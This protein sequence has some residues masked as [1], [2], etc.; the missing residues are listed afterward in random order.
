MRN[1]LENFLAVKF[2]RMTK[3]FLTILANVKKSYVHAK[4]PQSNFWSNWLWCIKMNSL[5]QCIFDSCLKIYVP[6]KQCLQLYEGE[7][8]HIFNNPFLEK[9]MNNLENLSDTKVL[10]V[11]K[12]CLKNLARVKNAMRAQKLDFWNN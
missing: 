3:S 7:I 2:S 6:R 5:K 9:I 1:Y 8:I 10:Y 11:I 12:S 4:L